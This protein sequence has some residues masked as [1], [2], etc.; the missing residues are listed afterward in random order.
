MENELKPY[1]KKFDIPI[2]DMDYVVKKFQLADNCQA[3]EFAVRLLADLGK[4]NDMGWNMVLAKAKNEDGKAVWD[5]DYRYA[6]FDINTLRPSEQG[7]AR[8]SPNIF[9]ENLKI[10]L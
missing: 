10:K 6:L 4:C 8:I 3:I 1:F 7:F 9:E 2:E 5:Q